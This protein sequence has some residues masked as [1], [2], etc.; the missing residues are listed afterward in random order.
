MLYLLMGSLPRV[1]HATTRAMSAAG[2]PATAVRTRERERAPAGAENSASRTKI[3]PTASVGT[4]CAQACATR[5]PDEHQIIASSPHKPAEGEREDAEAEGEREVVREQAP[6]TAA[7][8]APW[9]SPAA[10]ASGAL[11]PGLPPGPA[12]SKPSPVQNR[13][14]VMRTA[15]RQGRNR[16]SVPNTARTQCR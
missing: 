1:C 10:R 16:S 15:C 7:T 3:K 4:T 13:Q 9:R 5:K 11:C 8:A 2:A 12:R 14:R 6:C